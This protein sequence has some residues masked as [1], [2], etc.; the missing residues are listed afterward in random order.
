[1]SWRTKKYVG[2]FLEA[3]L[4]TVFTLLA[5]ASRDDI[6]KGFL[7]FDLLTRETHVFLLWV[8]IAA[9]VFTVRLQSDKYAKEAERELISTP[10]FA[11]AYQRALGDAIKCLLDSFQGSTLPQVKEGILK[12]VC[13]V[14]QRYVG[15]SRNRRINTNYMLP[16]EPL[17]FVTPG[18][19][20]SSLR[21]K[22]PHLG[23]NDCECILTIR[24][25]AQRDPGM[26]YSFSLPVYK[27]RGRR[28]ILF[29]APMAYVTGNHEIVNDCLW[30]WRR[31]GPE[32]SDQVKQEMKKYFREQKKSLRSFAS[33]AC[34]ANGSVVAVLNVQ[35]NQKRVLGRT[36]DAVVHLLE[37]FMLVLAVLVK[38]GHA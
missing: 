38:A 1:M 11:E 22:E 5:L 15:A 14:V 17:E 9:V 36:P 35:S 23:L 37:P 6:A 24:E 32:V 16:K 18:Q 31:W 28:C 30:L 34:K 7:S 33:L 25:W 21:F 8:A 20:A 12:S 29:G 26:P 27:E 4:A 2:R 3:C 13:G 10:E 19:L